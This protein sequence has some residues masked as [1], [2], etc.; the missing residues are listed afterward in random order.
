MTTLI[1]TFIVILI[2]WSLMDSYNARKQKKLIDTRLRKI[3]ADI[4][5]LHK[6]AKLVY[7]YVK[8]LNQR[9]QKYEKGQKVNKA[10][11]IRPKESV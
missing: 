7:S 8:D 1:F 2:V 3:S 11:V 10:A 4:N 9:L 5:T 6:N